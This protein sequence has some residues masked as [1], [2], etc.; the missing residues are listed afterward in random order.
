MSEAVKSFADY[1][2]QFALSVDI[3]S[4][5]TFNRVRN[6][7][8]SYMRDELEAAYFGLMAKQSINRAPG[9]R[10]IWSSAGQEHATTIKDDNQYTRHV[11][12]A[13]DQRK[14]LWI[15]AKDETPLRDA[16]EYID[17]WS[18]ITDLPRYVPPVDKPMKTSIMLPLVRSG[19]ALGVIYLES[20]AYVEATEV[21]K[22]ELD[23]LADAIAILMDLREVNR[24][25]AECTGEAVEQLGGFLATAKFPRLTKPNLFV[26][27]AED[28][29]PRVIDIIRQVLAQ[30]SSKATI[31]D[32]RDI[33]DSGAITSQIADKIV[34]SRFGICYF[35]EPAVQSSE[36]K[37]VDN[38][39]VIFEAGMLHALINSPDAPPSG[40]IPVREEDSPAAPFDFAAERIEKV[41]RNARGELDEV[42]LRAQL[43]RRLNSLLKK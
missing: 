40:W 13:F 6:L 16:A 23:V 5:D 35:S 31:I 22:E 8:V 32:W 19:R 29:D 20:T 4:D 27:S 36:H 26:A 9:L 38:P 34:K 41:P 43:E 42:K 14:P 12:I 7:V 3:V 37:Y 30:F 39:N 11:S 15:V 10:T 33:S 17:L 21:A 24:S 25:Q 1:L 28:A 18:D 2:K